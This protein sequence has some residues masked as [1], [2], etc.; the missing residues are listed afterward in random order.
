LYKANLH[1]G[2][3]AAIINK[4]ALVA[5]KITTSGAQSAIHN[6]DE[7]TVPRPADLAIGYCEEWSSNPAIQLWPEAGARATSLNLEVKQTPD[8][9]WESDLTKWISPLEFGAVPDDGLDDS[10]A[11]Q[12]AIDAAD[13]RHATTLYLPRVDR[14]GR[15]TYHVAKTVVLRSKSLR[16]VIGCSAWVYPLEPLR[17]QVDTPVFRIE[18]GGEP[19]VMERMWLGAWEKPTCVM[20]EDASD[21][22]LIFR[23][24]S[25]L[26]DGYTRFTAYRKVSGK[27]NEIY[28]EDGSPGNF[29]TFTKGQKIWAR[30]M[31]PEGYRANNVDVDGADFWCLGM[32]LEGNRPAVE[33]R[34]GGRAEILGALFYPP[35]GV[36]DGVPM[37]KSIDSQLTCSMGQVVFGNKPFDILVEEIRH[38]VTRRMMAAHGRPWVNSAAIILFTTGTTEPEG[39]SRK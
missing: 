13:A 11:L 27:A 21:R 8:V 25:T 2:G 24:F 7:R 30:Q 18:G 36:E 37:F 34:G 19:L 23:E 14:N 20:I 16:R 10:E 22:T 6:M 4:K 1:S 5:R 31:N 32:K 17:Y 33:V 39:A 12:K 3:P 38:G 26:G 28:I 29:V 35:L 15:G 9:A